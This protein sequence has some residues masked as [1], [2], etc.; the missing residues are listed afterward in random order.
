MNKKSFPIFALVGVPNVGKSSLVNRLV[1]S[2]AAIIHDEAHTTRDITRH[3]VTWGNKRL[4]VQD[5]P[6]FGKSGDVLTQ[7]AQE[8]LKASFANA[9]A[10]GFV[11]DS[12]QEHITEAEKQ[13]ARIVRQLG[14]P[15]VLLYNKI[16]KDHG[17]LSHFRGLGLTNK[18]EISAHHGLGVEE[19]QNWVSA[20]VADNLDDADLEA[21]RQ[22]RVAI[23]GRPNVGKS[24][25]LNKLTGETSAIV[26]EIAGTTRDPIS[27]TFE[28]QGRELLITDTAGLRRPG[29]I[30][31]SIEYFSLTRTRQVV[32]AADV[33][34]L[35]ID[36]T[37]PATSQDQRIAGIVREAG[38][39]LVLVV[40]KIDALDEDE[41]SHNRLEKRLAREFE[42]VWWAPY[43]LISAE[44]G[45]HID[46]LL[47]Q[48]VLVADRVNQQF[49]TTEINN[50]LQKAIINKPPAGLHNLRPKINYATQTSVNP[51]E[52]TLYG[53]HPESIHFSY[54][55]YLEN[56]LRDSF[57]LQGAPIKLIFKSKY[58]NSVTP[59]EN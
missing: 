22:L 50:V 38:K 45:R 5:T 59:T 29:K 24:S 7:A 53:T 15:T 52:I 40:N 9:S 14:K 37:E 55:R 8:Q 30:G 12:T 44:T 41:R 33:C 54:R 39:G 2:R 6:G 4:Y 17:E 36:A 28:F 13:L 57:D 56:Q 47:E 48:V 23:L 27:T 3:E 21:P 32:D 35:I 18:L 51:L 42:F 19:L 31:R 10:I 25:L 20:Q 26:S 46:K 43:V 11:I 34:V 58:G 16:D 1:S 49:R